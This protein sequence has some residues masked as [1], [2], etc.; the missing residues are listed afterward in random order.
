MAWHLLKKECFSF[1]RHVWVWILERVRDEGG[2]EEWHP[3]NALGQAQNGI[4]TID[5]MWTKEYFS[6][7]PMQRSFLEQ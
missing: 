3:P 6:P 2:G 1:P 4:F 5:T 7:I